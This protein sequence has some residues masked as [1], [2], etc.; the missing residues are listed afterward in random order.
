MDVLSRTG[1][2]DLDRSRLA[3]N[4]LSIQSI[5]THFQKFPSWA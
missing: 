4:S 3:Y 2:A 1:G 5:L